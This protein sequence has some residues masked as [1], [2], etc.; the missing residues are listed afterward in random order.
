MGVMNIKIRYEYISSQ[1]L[2]IG[3]PAVVQD[4]ATD[5]AERAAR[6]DMPDGAQLLSVHW[7]EQPSGKFGGRVF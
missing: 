7:E 6:K 1:E 2:D 4:K 5:I 3:V